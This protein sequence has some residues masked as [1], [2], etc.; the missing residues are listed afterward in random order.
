MEAGQNRYAERFILAI[1][2]QT[3]VS[4][5]E[6]YASPCKFVLPSFLFKGLRLL[7]RWWG[8]R[9]PTLAS[10]Y[11]SLTPNIGLVQFGD[12]CISKSK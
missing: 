3:Y 4:H 10:V 6:N 9:I 7:T 11:N 5:E 12:E 1:D 8:G 2:G